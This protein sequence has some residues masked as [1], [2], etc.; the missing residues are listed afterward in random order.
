MAVTPVR[1][2]P[3][4][5]FS[6]PSPEMSVVTPTSTPEM[7]VIALSGPGVPSNGT[8]RSRAR[9]LPCAR[10]SGDTSAAATAR[11]RIGARCWSLIALPPGT[12]TTKSRKHEGTRRRKSIF[13]AGVGERVAALLGA[14]HGQDAGGDEVRVAERSRG[15]LFV[16]LFGFGVVRLGNRAL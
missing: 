12:E 14:V 15:Q 3:L 16:D 2:G 5:T 11:Q 13:S 7:S 8:P 10:V 1:T 6:G 4:P 9:G